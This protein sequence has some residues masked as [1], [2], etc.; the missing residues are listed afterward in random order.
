MFNVSS[1]IGYGYRKNSYNS[2]GVSTYGDLQFPN[3]WSIEN[4]NEW[5]TIGNKGRVRSHSYGS[6]VMH[7]VMASATLSY[8]DKVYLEL[9]GR[10]DWNSTLPSYNNSYFYPGVAVNW[11]FISDESSPILNFAKVRLAWADVGRGAP[12][13][14]FLNNNYSASL[15]P[16]TEAIK[17]SS[18]TTLISDYIKPERK[19]EYELGIDTRMFQNRVETNLSYYRSN[20]YDQISRINVPQSSALKQIKFNVG[21]QLNYGVELYIRGSVIK[22]R[23]MRLD[24]TATAAIQRSKIKD[25]YNGITSNPIGTVGNSVIVRATEGRPYGEIYMYDFKRDDAG[26]KLVNKDGFYYLDRD[27]EMTVQGNITDKLLGGFMMDYFVKGF[28]IH[29]GLDYRLGGKLFS[30]SNYY[31]LGNGISE[32]SL[33]YRDEDHGGLAYYIDDSS[34][35][36][37]QWKHHQAAPETAYKG[38]VYHDGVILPGKVEN[39]DGNNVTY[40]NNEKILSAQEYYSQYINDMSTDFFP[41]NLYKNDYIKLREV[42]VSYTFPSKW[43]KSI[44]IQKLTLSAMGRNLFYIYKSIPN[45]DS[46]STLGSNSFVENSFYPSTRSYGFGI[47]VSF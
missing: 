13:Y 18:P 44:G 11:N 38:R 35:E 5:P 2:I 34:Q 14:Y 45:I 46:E 20:T 41:D 22:T 40:E 8:R 28:N 10:K 32:Q 16:N 33:D 1:F 12:G 26:N 36:R 3:Y 17:I 19:R 29:I 39:K 15:V 23:D 9:Q 27:K 31:L 6:R 43:S 7:S 30:Y 24:L 42:A 21:E 4:I 37:I 47:N 25:L